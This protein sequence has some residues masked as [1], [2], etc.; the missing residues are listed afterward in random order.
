MDQLDFT[1]IYSQHKEFVWRLVSRFVVTKEDR[2][3]LFQEVFIRIYRA[4]GKF[5]GQSKLETW[6]YR[7]TTNTAINYLNKQK[8]IRRVKELLEK[9]RIISSVED[10]E[11][12]IEGSLLRPLEKL[13]SKQKMILLLAEVEELPLAQIAE[14]MN[15]PIGTVKSNLNRAKEIMRK[16]LNEEDLSSD[17]SA[18][19]RRTKEEVST[20]EEKNG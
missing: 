5:K 15:I 19:V 12:E 10:K 13:N 11:P 6:L 8:R 9:M 3:D 14:N 2:E 7:L 20:K 16:S 1:E 18:E 4:L 17:L